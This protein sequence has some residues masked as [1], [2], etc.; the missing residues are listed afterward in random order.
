MGGD[1][2]QIDPQVRALPPEQ[3]GADIRAQFCRP[4]VR[5]E[6]IREQLDSPRRVVG[7]L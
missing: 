3:V 2:R 4:E 6:T 7:E 1:E 5:S